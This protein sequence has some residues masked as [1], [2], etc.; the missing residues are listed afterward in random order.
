MWKLKLKQMCYIKRVTPNIQKVKI[1]YKKSKKKYKKINIQWNRK[2]LEFNPVSSKTRFETAVR[3]HKRLSS[4]SRLSQLSAYF[5]FFK[6]LPVQSYLIFDAK[7]F[8]HLIWIHFFCENKLETWRELKCSFFSFYSSFLYLY[9]W[10]VR[11][12]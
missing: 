11:L 2:C 5:Y 8:A 7:P 4:I 10:V 1:K 3:M 6:S 12:K 9:F